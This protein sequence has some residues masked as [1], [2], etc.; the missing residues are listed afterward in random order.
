MPRQRAICFGPFQI[1]QESD[2]LRQEGTVIRL[3]PKSFAVL[4]YLAEHPRRLITKDELLEAVWP[5]I[6]VSESV[7][8]VCLSEL[9]KALGDLAQSPRYIE[10]V[11]RRGYRF[12]GTMSRPAPS[13]DAARVGGH[14]RPPVVGRETELARLHSWWEEARRGER[15]VAFVTGESGIGKTTVVDVFV[16]GAAAREEVWAGRGQCIEHY[17]GSEP[18]LSVLDALSRLCRGPE[19]E[20]VKATL[21]QYAPTWL[22]QMPWFLSAD[23]QAALGRRLLGSTRERM[24]RE[25]AEAVEALSRHRPLLLVLED[26]HWSDGATVDL[27]AWLARRRESA[28]LLLIGTFRT[29]DLIVGGHPLGTVKDELTRQ[30]CCMELV[31]QPLTAAGVTQYLSALAPQAAQGAPL[32]ELALAIHERTDG[33]PLFMVTLVDHL[34]QRG[35]DAAGDGAWP[36]R[37]AMAEVKRGLPDSLRQMIEQQLQTLPEDDQR[38]LEAASVLGIEFSA[39]SVA[40]GR[41]TGVVAAEEHCAALARQERFLLR[42]GVEEWPGGMVANRYRFRHGLHQQVVY[43]RIPEGSRIEL[44]RRVGLQLEEGHGADARERAAE[45]AGHFERGRDYSR[46]VRYRQQAGD[47]ALWRCAYQET[48]EHL[49][50]ALTLLGT[51]PETSERERSELALLTTLGPALIVTRGHA[52]TDVEHVYVRARE[53]CRQLHATAPLFPVLRGLSML[54]LNRAELGRVRELAEERLRLSQDQHDPVLLLGAHD[55]LGAILYHLGELVLARTHLEQGIALSRTPGASADVV[56]DAA[57]DHGVACLGHLAWTLWF[58]GQPGQAQQRSREAITRAQGLAHP[59]SLTQALYW[60]AQ[61]HQFCQDARGTQER[62][63]AA[64]AI[65]AAQGFAQQQA[66][67]LLLQGWALARQGH[68]EEGIAQMRQ[69][70]ADWEATGARLLRPYYLVSL[71]RACVR[72]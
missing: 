62:A 8:T 35:W 51:L 34:V 63:Q 68:R 14:P 25:F 54:Y 39:A 20:H 9:R 40:A 72:G 15:R 22:A 56:Q 32:R 29:V 30:R 64:M 23:E 60:G 7:L 66:Q 36:G 11:P 61:L 19:G 6:V 3:R 44:H 43:E 5:G 57:T 46:A 2:Q 53:L 16:A 28:R 27:L 17:G 37:T 12:V 4:R 21:H 41:A 13:A 49:T 31:M 67:A 52:A 70:F 47:N 59:F 42:G 71:R 26:L 55:A 65:A 18:Y 58:L 69:G 1:D 10:T 45:L 24:L 50:T 33:H 38:V 48:V